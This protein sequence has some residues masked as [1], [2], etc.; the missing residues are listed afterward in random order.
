VIGGPGAFVIVAR[1]FSDFARAV[2]AKLQ[3]EIAGEVPPAG[4]LA[5]AAR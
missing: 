3:L 2:L 1:D 4:H 5:T